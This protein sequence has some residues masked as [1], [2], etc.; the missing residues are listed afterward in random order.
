[1]ALATDLNYSSLQDVREEAGGQHSQKLVAL[2]GATD[3]ANVD[4]VASRSY[5]VDRNY[6]DVITPNEDVIV[7]DDDVPVTV[8]TVNTTSGAIRLSSAPATGSRMLVSYDYSP[9]NDVLINKRRNE[10]IDFV[11][12]SLSGIIDYAKWETTDVPPT[13]QAVVRLYAGALILIRDIGLDVDTEE[14][15]KD[16]YKKLSTAKSMLKSYLEEVGGSAGSTARVGV[17]TKSDGNLFPRNT[18]LTNSAL[19]STTT[20][21]FMRKD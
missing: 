5:I 3:G 18:D 15:S 12:R 8:S 4:F 19:G 9:Y 13:I 1:M 11:K 2:T 6:D 21:D 20:E 14:S 16:G 7:Y 17:S 10:A